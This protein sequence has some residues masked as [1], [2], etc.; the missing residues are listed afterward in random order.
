MV[1]RGGREAVG[2]SGEES[3]LVSTCSEESSMFASDVIRSLIEDRGG[4]GAGAAAGQ[5]LWRDLARSPHSYLKSLGQHVCVAWRATT[6]IIKQY[7]FKIHVSS[8][9]LNMNSVFPPESLRVAG[10]QYKP[11]DNRAPAS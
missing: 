2:S 7:S 4:S 6:P 8:N 3:T 5:I 10:N 11:R 9:R 1:E